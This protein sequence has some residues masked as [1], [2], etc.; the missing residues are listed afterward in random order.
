MGGRFGEILLVLIVALLL[1]G[2][3]KLPNLA[4]ALGEAIREFKKAANTDP[5]NQSNADKTSGQPA[6]VKTPASPGA[7][8]NSRRRSVIRRRSKR[9]R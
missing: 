5:D 4:K 2:P 9:T 1:F 8:T 6:S 7:S 3:S